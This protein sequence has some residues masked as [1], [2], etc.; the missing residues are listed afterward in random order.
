MVPGPL[1]PLGRL[2]TVPRANEPFKAYNIS[3]EKISQ[4]KKQQQILI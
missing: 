1:Y 2:G 3:L 4:K